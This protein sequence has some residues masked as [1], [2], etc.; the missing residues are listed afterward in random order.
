MRDF[1]QAEIFK[2]KCPM[3]GSLNKKHVPIMYKHQPYGYSLHC[4]N[5]G[6]VE[7]FI[8]PPKS[9]DGLYNGFFNAGEVSEQKC[10]ALNKCDIENCPWFGTY[11]PDENSGYDDE[12]VDESTIVRPPNNNQSRPNPSTQDLHLGVYQDSFLD[13]P[14]LVVKVNTENPKFL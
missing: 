10:Y 4:C 6:H 5:C 12:Q 9:L 2:Y 14:E 3:C 1:E 8:T 7:Q 11:C 13:E